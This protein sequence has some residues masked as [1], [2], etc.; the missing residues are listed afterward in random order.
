MACQGTAD[1]IGDVHGVASVMFDNTE[2]YY[3]KSSA[4]FVVLLSGEDTDEISLKAMEEIRDI[5][6]PYDVSISTTVGIDIVAQLTKDMT[7]VGVLAAIIIITVLMFTSQSYA[8]VPL[9]LVIFGVAA[10]LNVGT[11]FMLGKISFISNSVGVILQLALAIDYAIIL[12]HRFNEEHEH[13]PA[14]DAAI[15]A[16]SKAIP[17]ISSSSLTTV[18]GLGALAFMQFGIGKDLAAVMIKAILLSMLSVFTIL[19]YW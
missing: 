1:K 4:L 16:L 19:A 10:L 3:K 9:L 8:E 5:V 7:I 14:R 13:L 15:L 12:C 6:S 11:N 17:E 18:A 2:D